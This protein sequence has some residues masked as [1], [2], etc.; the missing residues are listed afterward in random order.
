MET[1]NTTNEITLT[2]ESKMR[3]VLEAYPSAQRA[4]MRRYHIGGCSS[5]GFAPDD[6]LGDVLKKHNV[7][8]VDEVIEHIKDSQEQEQRIQLSTKALAELLKGDNPPKLIDVRQPDEQ[9]IVKLEGALPAT[10]ELM[11]EMNGNWDKGTPIV[12]YCHHG[13]RSLEAASFL[14]GHG[15]TNVRSLSGGIDAW[16]EE[17]DT[18]LKRY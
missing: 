15:F 2:S 3:E 9:A 4:L 18:S 10:Q 11:Q 5:C 14:I 16:A 12:T 6:M 7:L 13:V 17:I 1:S 8:A